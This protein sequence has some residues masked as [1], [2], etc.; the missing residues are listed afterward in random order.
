M[1]FDVNSLISTFFLVLVSAGAYYLA[2]K[3]YIRC[4]SV[5]TTP[6]M[7]HLKMV[8]SEVTK[9]DDIE[10][11]GSQLLMGRAKP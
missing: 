1:T 7:N 11:E 6:V 2:V 4:N 5:Q 9:K 8:E 10:S 3:V